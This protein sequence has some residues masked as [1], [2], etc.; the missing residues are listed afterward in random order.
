MAKHSRAAISASKTALRGV[1]TVCV[2]LDNPTFTLSMHAHSLSTDGVCISHTA[3][4]GRCTTRSPCKTASHDVAGP[5]WPG[6]STRHTTGSSVRDVNSRPVSARTSPRHDLHA[7]PIS[8]RGGPCH[9]TRVCA[10]P[11]VRRESACHTHGSS[12]GGH[13]REGAFAGGFHAPSTSTVRGATLCYLGEYVTVTRTF[14]RVV[15]GPEAYIINNGIRIART[16]S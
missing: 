8:L 6:P 15:D 12:R 1:E 3:R 7:S 9:G 2:T 4:D 16:H 11:R 14:C 5:H 13:T 10:T